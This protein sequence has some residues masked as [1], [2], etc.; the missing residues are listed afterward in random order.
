MNISDKTRILF[1]SEPGVM[2]ESMHAVLAALPH[3]AI[4][5]QASGSL[6]ALHLLSRCEAEVVVIDTNIPLEEMLALVRSINAMRPRIAC[7]ALASTRSQMRLAVAEG[8]CA[9]LPRSSP[10]Q[11]ISEA[12][13]SAAR[14]IDQS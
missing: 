7:I 11:Q 3:I 13:Q 8:A 9:A 12:I 6:S 5:G 10:P 4:V 14:Q 2:Q 1:V